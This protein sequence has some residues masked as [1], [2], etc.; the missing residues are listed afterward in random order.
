MIK[1]L[2]N[3]IRWISVTIIHLMV[4]FLSND[5]PKA[6]TRSF[7]EFYLALHRTITSKRKIKIQIHG[8]VFM[9]VAHVRWNKCSKWHWTNDM[10]N[11]KKDKASPRQ[12]VGYL[13]TFLFSGCCNSHGQTFIIITPDTHAG[14]CFQDGRHDI[15]TVIFR[16]W[17]QVY[18]VSISC[19]KQP[20]VSD[21]STSAAFF[22]A[23]FGGAA[24][25]HSG[26]EQK[27]SAWCWKRL[28]GALSC[29]VW[30]A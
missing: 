9:P 24:K 4:L 26:V 15:S 23:T 25:K 29:W 6:L 27:A 8:W 17:V 1:P 2:Q 28:Q 5:N 14:K 11:K 16:F 18:N 30:H 21:H 13:A 22:S 20:K 7:A 19:I 10:S 12:N 3:P